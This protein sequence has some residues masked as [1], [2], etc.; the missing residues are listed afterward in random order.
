MRVRTGRG[1]ARAKRGLVGWGGV[2]P[3][4]A[5]ERTRIDVVA[6]GTGVIVAARI[7]GVAGKRRDV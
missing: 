2:S 3:G 5:G 1:K 4:K 7:E 6:E